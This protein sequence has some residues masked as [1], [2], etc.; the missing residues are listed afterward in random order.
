MSK[1]YNTNIIFNT[2]NKYYNYFF[3][4]Y[5]NCKYPKV[6]C[7]N[8][9]LL[10][11]FKA[12]GFTSNGIHITYNGY[13]QV[14][15]GENYN[16]IFFSNFINSCK[17]R[18]ILLPIL[19]FEIYNILI[20]DTKLKQVELFN[21]GGETAI[22]YYKELANEFESSNPYAYNESSY[23]D[24]IELT[25]NLFK[26]IDNKIKF[27]TPVSFFPKHNKIIEVK[28]TWTYKINLI[29]NIMKALTTRKLGY[30]FEFWIYDNK[31]IKLVL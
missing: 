24:Y 15:N 28:N 11:E 22:H 31:G 3:A 4:N 12:I 29:K 7:M 5:L 18:F 13:S 8:P 21:P 25:K 27:F 14:Y 17:N 9:D 16:S 19:Y 23:A 6:T 2:N 10:L 26:N 20:Y 30:D 1:K